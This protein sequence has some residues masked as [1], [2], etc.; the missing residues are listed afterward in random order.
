[1]AKTRTGAR[2][3][4]KEIQHACKLSHTAGFR[5]GL[6]TILGPDGAADL[7]ALWTPLCT[8][9]ESIVA[10]DDFFNLIDAT[11]PSEEGGEDQVLS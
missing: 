3:F 4:L 8:L 10:L 6:T 11:T 5:N 1:M 9:F 7:Y 2:T